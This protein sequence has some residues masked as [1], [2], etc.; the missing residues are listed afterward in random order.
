MIPARKTR[1]IRIRDLAVGG[2]APIA[3]QSMAATR[4]RDVEATLRQVRILEARRRRPRAHRGRQ[5][6]D[7]E[8]L[9]KIRARTQRAALGRPAGELPPR[10]RRSR[11]T[12]TRS[13]TTPATCTTTRRRSRSREKVAFLVDV[14]ARARLRAAHRRQRGLDRARSTR[15]AS[16]TTT[17]AAIVA[18]RG[19][20]LRD[21]RRARLHATTSSRSRTPTRASSSTPTCASPPRAPTCRCTSA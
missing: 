5:P 19:R 15:S 16:A 12:S 17:S 4:T 21:G 1:T 11:R 8:A 20:P 14:G 7:V 9:A 18:V 13:A 3:V 10:G 6:A 2:D